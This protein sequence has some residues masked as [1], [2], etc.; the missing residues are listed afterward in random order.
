[1][2]E[3]NT[4]T[5]VINREKTRFPEHLDFQF[6]RQKGIDHLASL[7]GNLWTD[8]NVHDPGI[9]ILENLVYALLDLGYASNHKFEDLIALK[10]AGKEDEQEEIAD[11]I[12]PKGKKETLC[13]LPGEHSK[14]KDNNFFSASEILGNSPLTILD[15]RKL[16]IDQPGVRNAWIEVAKDEKDLCRDLHTEDCATFLN[17]LYHVYIDLDNS[18][19]NANSDSPKWREKFAK[20]MRQLL[21]AYRNLCEDFI[22][23]TVLCKE[24]IGLCAEIELKPGARLELVFDEIIDQ[25]RNFITPAPQ[26]YSLKQ[27][28]DKKWSMDKIFEGRPIDLKESH[29]F[30]DVSELNRLNLRKELRKSDIYQI[31]LDHKEVIS[32]KKLSFRN[33]DGTINDD[34]K[35][36]IAENHVP[37]FSLK[38]S[39]FRFFQQGVPLGYKLDDFLH[40]FQIKAPGARMLHKA[41]SPYLNPEVPNGRYREDLGEYY[42]V[43]NEFPKVYGIQ[44]GGL[45]PNV[46]AVRKAQAYQLKGYLLFFDQLL[47]N[48]LSQLQNIRS[49]FAL[50]NDKDIKHTYFIN[51]L[52]SVPDLHEILRFRVDQ[53]AKA[54]HTDLG[55]NLLFPTDR[56]QLEKWL[57]EDKLK[58][59]RPEQIPR[60]EFHNGTERDIAVQGLIND[61]QFL[62]PEPKFIQTLNECHYYYFAGTSQEVAYLSNA[63]FPTEQEAR[64]HAENVKFVGAFEENY[65]AFQTKQGGFSFL[66][67]YHLSTYPKYL[68]LITED[69]NLFYKRRHEFLNH[70]LSRFAEKFSDYALLSYGTLEE[71]A[72]NKNAISFKERF[73]RNYPE[74][75]S[76]RGKGYNYHTNRWQNN[77]ISGFENRF[78][79]IAGIRDLRRHDLCHFEVGEYEK[80]YIL[81]LQIGR[82]LITSSALFS[83]QNAAVTQAISLF[84]S[85]S[86]RTNYE[87]N[88][89]TTD[90]NFKIQICYSKSQFAEVDA[91]F[92]DSS[93][94]WSYV[95]HLQRLFTVIPLKE[96]TVVS[97]YVYQPHLVDFNGNAVITYKGNYN[98]KKEALSGSK[99]AVKQLTDS[100][101]WQLKKGFKKKLGK[102]IPGR[103]ETGIQSYIDVDRFKIDVNDNIVGKPHAFTYSFL[104]QNNSYKLNASIEFANRGQA[105]LGCYRL[106]FYLT[107]LKYYRTETEKGGNMHVVIHDGKRTLARS[108]DSFTS[109][110]ELEAYREKIYDS[111][112]SNCYDLQIDEMPTHW[113]YQYFL[114]SGREDK[115][116]FRSIEDFPSV[117]RALRAGSQFAKTID[118]AQL[119]IRNK[120]LFI[121]DKKKGVRS[122]CKLFGH[123]RAGIKKLQEI[124]EKTT[125]YFAARQEVLPF[126]QSTNRKLF[127][128]FIDLDEKSKK[129]TYVYRLVDND[130]IMAKSKEKFK[131][132]QEAKDFR[133]SL[134]KLVLK[135]FNFLQICLGGDIIVKRKD[136]KL[137]KTLYHYQIICRDAYYSKGRN[138]GRAIVLF[139]GTRGY[140]S[141]EKALKAFQLHYLKILFWAQKRKHYGKDKKIELTRTY[142]SDD[143]CTRGNSVVFVPK[144]TLD[145]LG[146]YEEQAIRTIIA[147]V[148][149]YPILYRDLK[150]YRIRLIHPDTGVEIWRGRDKYDTQEEARKAFEFFKVLLKYTGNYTILKGDDCCYRIYIRE[151]LAESRERFLKKDRAWSQLENF[152]NLAQQ[153]KTI[154][155]E[156]NTKD[157]CYANFYACESDFLHPCK[158]HSEEERDNALNKLFRAAREFNPINL[159]QIEAYQGKYA[160]RDLKDQRIAILKRDPGKTP[161]TYCDTLF[162]LVESALNHKNYRQSEDRIWLVDKGNRELLVPFDS[163]ISLECWKEL[164]FG[165]AYYFPLSRTKEKDQY[166]FSL[167]IKLPGFN[168]FR[169]ALDDSSCICVEAE[170]TDTICHIA[171]K[172]RCRYDSCQLAVDYFKLAM[173]LLANKVNYRP[174]YE[175][176]CGPYGVVLIPEDAIIAANPQCYPN[177]KMACEA[178]ERSLEKLNCEGLHLV[179]HLLLRPRCREDCLCDGYTA[180]CV[181]KTGCEF[182]WKVTTEDPCVKEDDICFIPGQDPYSFI[183]TAV[184]PAWP[185]RFRS[186]ENKELVERLLRQE[187]PAHVLLRVLWLTPQEFCV[188]ETTFRDWNRYLAEKPYCPDKKKINCKLLDLLVNT[189]YRCME[190]ANPCKPCSEEVPIALPCDETPADS[191]RN[192]ETKKGPGYDLTDFAN[193]INEL[194][195]WQN[196]ECSPVAGETSED[197]RDFVK[198]ADSLSKSEIEHRDQIKV[199]GERRRILEEKKK[200]QESPETQIIKTKVTRKEDRSS[201]LRFY[202][203]RRAKR[204]KDIESIVKTSSRNDNAVR[205]HRFAQKQQ[206]R[207][208]ELC[209]VLEDVLANKKSSTT[210]KVL[211]KAQ[212]QRLIAKSV[213]F[214][215]DKV[216]YEKQ[217]LRQTKAW[218]TLLKRFEEAGI[219]AE[220]IYMQWEPQRISKA[221]QKVNLDRIKKWL[222]HP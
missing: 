131:T 78:K 179:E 10:P 194:Y 113:K 122:W 217:V 13:F 160:I 220:K 24:E 104:D 77:N 211:T 191:E 159:L 34:W 27:L 18:P 99:K 66:L 167:E 174:V 8:H 178:I 183:A 12:K 93:E 149:S 11:I 147:R 175:C 200:P 97:R 207:L 198:K 137:K 55:D 53:T 180:R 51:D 166:K 63:I 190:D 3:N 87:V 132:E 98:D 31:L 44:E 95:D 192:D 215:L 17:G 193:Q 201:I 157:C 101:L 216:S 164:L 28:L 109:R 203:S 105:R 39:G 123:D 189:K 84:Q 184:L 161:E 88:Y 218:K 126:Y 151:V 19:Q 102:M 41:D 152:I 14:L 165:W 144:A 182:K 47:A 158:Y 221:N 181:N 195:C 20:K 120:Q 5:Q 73:L 206:P 83:S 62:D 187:T 154:Y 82:A 22:D 107:N 106:L 110:G 96:D 70:L 214:Y 128:R 188:F 119:E 35:Y 155:S 150:D 108:E 69:Q 196:Q 138:K 33:C 136:Q 74:I 94:A 170:V 185:Q 143:P 176:E 49:L 173:Y 205:I 124:K 54:K 30:L 71:E 148:R 172:G 177:P 114:G 46:S 43:Q 171:W 212:M 141:K 197:R 25:L 26:F 58:R 9:T 32:V 103:R 40:T 209:K 208:D 64:Q 210:S 127:E 4:Q 116:E 156:V 135:G 139:E 21:M 79:A 222:G 15:Y 134:F 168:D 65:R 42:S 162:T 48:Y 125:V 118:K 121:S 45:A 133:K 80:N 204:V 72:I 36:Q 186:Q 29:G 142:Y 76:K 60:Y 115:Y 57:T 37:E 85:L 86:K 75:S 91:S 67:E 153:K 56:Y 90:L 199:S 16:L 52:D 111:A 89:D 50:H 117:E 59:K 68:Q 129:G 81:R 169:S 6:L 100:K 61:L 219:S 38:C 1:M 145:E 112:C 92:A 2:P 7:S 140:D 146:G 163:D 130:Q 213:S 202:N 23:V